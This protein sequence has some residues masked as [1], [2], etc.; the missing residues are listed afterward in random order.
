VAD[1]EH[2]F[3]TAGFVVNSH[4]HSGEPTF[5]AESALKFADEDKLGNV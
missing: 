5:T 3:I 1:V 2:L 4:I